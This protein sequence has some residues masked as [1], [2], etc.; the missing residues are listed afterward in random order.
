MQ[1]HY[2]IKSCLV[3]SALLCAGSIASGYELSEGS[4]YF[5]GQF[6]ML[7]YDISGAN[8]SY[9]PTA[10]VARM[11]L[12]VQDNVAIEGRIGT[13]LSSDK[14]YYTYNDAD[15]EVAVELDSLLGLFVI[16][17][18]PLEGTGS[19]YGALG[20]SR[21]RTSV[22]ED[23]YWYSNYF[24]DMHFN[25]T[26]TV[27]DT[28]LSYGVGFEWHMSDVSALNIE[29]MMYVNESDY[30]VAALSVGASFGF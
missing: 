9:E 29:Y 11:G 26:Y 3:A 7:D 28:G 14:K 27:S 30:S 22:E 20:L 23:D 17:H 13:G 18:M 15:E 8:E 16:A 12:F 10:L 24:G 2:F 1:R 5:G 4:R 19:F 25:D 21:V 6:A